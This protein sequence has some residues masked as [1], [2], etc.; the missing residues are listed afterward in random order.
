[1]GEYSDLRIRRG[2][3]SVHVAAACVVVVAV[4]KTKTKW[5]MAVA[6]TNYSKTSVVE[7]VFGPAVAVEPAALP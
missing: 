5:T 6:K 2:I 7:P 3:D 1:M 4:V